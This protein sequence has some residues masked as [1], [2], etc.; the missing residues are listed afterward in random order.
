VKQKA[1][2]EANIALMGAYEAYKQLA[3][4]GMRFHVA[5]ANNHDRLP[6]HMWREWRDWKK[7]LAEV[8]RRIEKYYR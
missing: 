1:R 5:K 4:E 3:A 2:G 7:R 6:L 8:D